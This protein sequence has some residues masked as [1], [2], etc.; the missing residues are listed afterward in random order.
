LHHAAR[1]VWR[2][3]LHGYAVHQAARRVGD[4]EGSGEGAGRHEG[5]EQGGKEQF[6]HTRRPI[7]CAGQKGLDGI[8]F[9]GRR[10]ADFVR[11]GKAANGSQPVSGAED[12]A[13][14]LRT[15]K[16]HKNSARLNAI[17]AF[18]VCSGEFG[19]Q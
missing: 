12:Q 10:R 15:H 3:R 7:S 13:A 8:N 6:F 5:Q 11:A 18:L 14:L 9:C 1:F 4:A 19:Y 2:G 17:Y 16:P